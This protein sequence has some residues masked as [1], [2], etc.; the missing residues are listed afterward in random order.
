M[1]AGAVSWYRVVS[2]RRQTKREVLRS[3]G[4][5]F[6]DDPEEEPTTYLA[7]SLETAWLEV[8]AH[9]G[10]ARPDMRAFR[11]WRITVPARV[12]RRLVDLRAGD[13]QEHHRITQAELEA[14]P[15]PDSGKALARRLRK[16]GQAGVIYRSVRNRPAG[17]CA[18][19]FLESVEDELSAEPAKEEWERFLQATTPVGKQKRR[20]G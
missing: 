3:G 14:D 10:E 19:V 11:A 12:A 4:G 5:R 6:H 8:K 1:G 15:A 2:S 18:A 13:Q 7:D 9:A 20:D 16:G 17:V